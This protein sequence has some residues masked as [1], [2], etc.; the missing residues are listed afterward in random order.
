MWIAT[1]LD[2]TES[3]LKFGASLATTSDLNHLPSSDLAH[4]PRTLLTLHLLYPFINSIHY[5]VENYQNY[6]FPL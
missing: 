2:Q 5:L 6:I 1:L 3:Q 4:L